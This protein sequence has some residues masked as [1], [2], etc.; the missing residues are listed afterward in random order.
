MDCHLPAPHDTFN[1]FYANTAHGIKDILVHFTQDEYDHEENRQA[2]YIL[3]V[4]C[5]IAIDL[6]VRYPVKEVKKRGGNGTQN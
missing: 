5:G 2:A 3:H 1:F 4:R 6:W